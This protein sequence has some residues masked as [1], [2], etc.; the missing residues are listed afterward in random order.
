LPTCCL[1]SL[2]YR[3]LSQSRQR[4]EGRAIIRMKYNKIHVPVSCREEGKRKEERGGKRRK[5][6]RCLVTIRTAIL[7][8]SVSSS[9]SVSVKRPSVVR[10]CISK[11]CLFVGVLKILIETLSKCRAH[12]RA[13]AQ[14]RAGHCRR[15]TVPNAHKFIERSPIRCR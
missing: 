14:P 5:E 15:A 2:T 6:R 12:W 9:L 4:G 11:P 3:R 8:P 13:Q 1:E 7:I 10:Q